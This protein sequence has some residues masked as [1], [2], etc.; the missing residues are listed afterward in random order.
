MTGRPNSLLGEIAIQAASSDD[1]P[2]RRR[3][4]AGQLP[5]GQRG[6]IAEDRRPGADRRRPRLPV[7]RAGRLV[8]QPDALPGRGDRRVAHA[9]RRSSSRP[10]ELVELYNPAEVYAAFA[11]AAREAAGLPAEPT[12]AEDLLEAAGIAPGRGRRPVRRRGRR[13]GGRC[14]RGRCRTTR[15]RRPRACTTWR[16]PSRSAASRPRRACS[17][18]SR[19][20]P[21]GWR[22]CVGD[23][24]I[25]DDDDERL[26]LQADGHFE[27]RSSRRRIPIAGGS[28]RS[29]RTSSSSTIRPTS[30][31]TW[32]SRSP[33]RTRASRRA[34]DAVDR[35]RPDDGAVGRHDGRG[36]LPDPTDRRRH[37]SRRRAAAARAAPAPPIGCRLLDAELIDVARD[38]ARAVPPDLPRAVAGDR[39]AGRPVRPRPHARLLRARPASAVQHQHRR[40]AD[41]HRSPSTSGSPARAPN[42]WPVPGPVSG[43]RCSGHWAGRSRSIHARITCCSSPAAS[44]WPACAPWPTSRSPPAAG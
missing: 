1:L 44:A 24:M 16:S 39:I 21:R 43:S 33:R 26:R 31:A 22:A 17:P 5:Q 30:S 2:R 40:H 10:A 9:R 11:E 25:V 14:R 8:P 7:G 28:S 12:G 20:P 18:S 41:G 36:A 27:A 35:A 13:V 34:D 42:G 29:R 3:P 4:T 6:G 23:L 19:S 32:P 15:R 38:P 37:R